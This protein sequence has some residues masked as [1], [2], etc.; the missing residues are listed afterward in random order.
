MSVKVKVNGE[1]VVQSA[2]ADGGTDTTLTIDGKA[3]DAKA[4]GDALADKQ[5]KGNYA[6]YSDIPSLDGY[7]TEDYVNEKVASLS[8]SSSIELD[9]TLTQENKAADAK[10]VGDSISNQSAMIDD[11]FKSLPIMVADDGYTD[12]IGLRQPTAISAVKDGDTI[13]ITTL[14]D[15]GVASSTIVILDDD[16][17]PAI[18]NT[19]GTDCSVSFIGFSDEQYTDV[20]EVGA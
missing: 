7:A 17:F 19:D 16:G 3:A 1:W 12:I 13:T 18:I 14:L 8:P 9:T 4:V 20:S 6:L 15:G 5:P 10:A 2:I 11:K